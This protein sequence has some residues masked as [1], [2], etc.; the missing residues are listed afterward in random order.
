MNEHIND[1]D[2][3]LPGGHQMHQLRDGS[4]WKSED[5]TFEN[6]VQVTVSIPRWCNTKH[7]EVQRKGRLQS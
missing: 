2:P 3:V 5:F 7:N 1:D 6:T 4:P